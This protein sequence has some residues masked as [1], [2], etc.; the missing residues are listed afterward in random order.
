MLLLVELYA[1]PLYQPTTQ[2]SSSSSYPQFS[3]LRLSLSTPLYLYLH[4][5]FS[6]ASIKKPIPECPAHKFPSTDQT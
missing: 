4:N 5:H 3:S 2:F 6:V 1:I